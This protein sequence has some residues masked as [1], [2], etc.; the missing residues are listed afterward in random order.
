MENLET[1]IGN[2]KIEYMEES[3]YK[4]MSQTRTKTRYRGVFTICTINLNFLG[5]LECGEERFIRNETW[6]YRIIY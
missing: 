6:H 4:E 5:S 2:L 3:S 1:G